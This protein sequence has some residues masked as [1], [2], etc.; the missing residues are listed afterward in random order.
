MWTRSDRDLDIERARGTAAKKTT[1]QQITIKVEPDLDKK[2]LRNGYKPVYANDLDVIVISSDS[3][4][5]PEKRS[6]VKKED[7]MGNLRVGLM[8]TRTKVKGKARNRAHPVLN[9]NPIA[10]DRESFVQESGTVWTDSEIKSF[11]IDGDLQVTT[12]LWVKRVEYLSE[13]PYI[14]PIPKVATAFI[15]DLRDEKFLIPTSESDPT[16]QRIDAL[17]KSKV[18]SFSADNKIFFLND[19][20]IFFITRTVGRVGAENRIQLPVCVFNQEMNASCAVDHG[21][22]VK[23]AMHAQKSTPSFLT[24]HAMTLI[25]SHGA[26]FLLP[27]KPPELLSE[28]VLNNGLQR[29]HLFQILISTVINVFSPLDFWMFVEQNALL[30]II[31]GGD[32]QVNLGWKKKSL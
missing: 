1:N 5:E 25:L 30:L 4:S 26:K 23:V 18:C 14:F 32:V 8:A 6:S 7:V 16:P 12:E 3:E 21:S 31:L 17:I 9:A 28:A 11:V 24:L 2:N 13:I 27:N 22:L 19:W 10:F 29:A 20:V 15:I